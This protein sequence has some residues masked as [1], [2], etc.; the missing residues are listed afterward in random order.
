[1]PGMLRA[2]WAGAEA[3]QGQQLAWFCIQELV[4]LFKGRHLVDGANDGVPFLSQL[5]QR[6]HHLH[7]TAP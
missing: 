7:S 3:L 6:P 1:M 5:L 4:L 2:G